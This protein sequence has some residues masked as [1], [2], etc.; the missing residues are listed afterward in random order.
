[1]KA[2]IFIFLSCILTTHIFSQSIAQQW[3]TRYNGDAN[4]NDFSYALT[5]DQNDNVIVTGYVTYNATSKDMQTIKYDPAG[6]VVWSNS[7]DGVNH[8][9]DYSYAVTTDAAGNVYVTGRTDG[10]ATYSDMTTIKYTS[11]GAQAWVG[12]YNGPANGMDEGR[13]IKVDNSGNVFVAGKSQ[14]SGNAQDLVVVKYNS[15][16]VQQWAARYN[17]TGT[18]IEIAYSMAI[19]AGGDVYLT[20]TSIGTNSGS[21]YI[22]LKYDPSGNLSWQRRYNGP[23]NGG[24]IAI[25]VKLDAAQ[26]VYITGFSDGGSSSYDFATLKYDPAGNQQWLQ[27]YNS[28]ANLGDFATAMEVD[29]AGNVFVTGTCAAGTTL[30]DS[31]FATIKYN[32]NGALQWIANYVGPNNSTDVPRA[33]TLDADGNVYVTGSSF[34]VPDLDDY[35]TI[36]YNPSGVQQWIMTYNGPASSNDYGA[37]LGVSS[38]GEVYVTGRS[39]G[40]NTGYDFATIKYSRPLGIEPVTNNT[41][42]SFNLYQN[43]PN[44]FNPST[45]LKFDIP[46]PSNIKLEFFNIEGKEVSSPYYGFTGAGTYVY[47][48]DAS[49]IS[50]GVYFYRLTAGSFSDTKK[51]VLVR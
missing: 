29:A 2:V 43:Y 46:N 39:V 50:S 7:Y 23:A 34:I 38:T 27:R 31:N 10:G 13:C 42:K 9:G 41:P 18:G 48:F 49:S 11:A 14:G 40:V 16:G 5:L 28:V 37:S 30:T 47:S 21:D 36:K 35:A 19:N 25:S 3:V 26:N 4:T 44:P 15:S 33:I 6:N 51:M 45:K 1:M 12:I 22:L 20:G 24:D 8:G 17:Y 32:T